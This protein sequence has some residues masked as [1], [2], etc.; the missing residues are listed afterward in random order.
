MDVEEG[1]TEHFAP[2]ACRVVCEGL[3][4]AGFTPG[5]YSALSWWNSYL[6]E[7]KEYTRWVAHWNDFCAY[8]GEYLIWQYGTSKVDGINGEVDSNYYY[9]DF[10][11]ADKTVITTTATD[12]KTI[13]KTTATKTTPDIT[14]QVFT[15]TSGWLPVGCRLSETLRI[16]PALTVSRSKELECI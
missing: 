13:T 1:G 3:K 2:R 10:G 9:G 5:V 11:N 4:K 8:G 6:T 12:N 16:M 14:Y 7:I 15:D